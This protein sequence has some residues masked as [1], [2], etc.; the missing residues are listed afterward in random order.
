MNEDIERWRRI[1][2]TNII[3]SPY[4]GYAIGNYSGG[5][6]IDVF[7]GSSAVGDENIGPAYGINGS[8]YMIFI[9]VIL[10][11]IILAYLAKRYK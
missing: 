6:I 4:V 1:P 3:V 2:S 9:A 11:A 8:V 5:T 7:G 10:A